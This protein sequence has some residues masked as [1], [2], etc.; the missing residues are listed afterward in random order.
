VNI[1][2]ATEG[3]REAT[4]AIHTAIRVT[5]ADHRGITL[6]CVAP[7]YPRPRRGGR[8]RE[9]YERRVLGEI[10]QILANAEMDLRD[11]SKSRDW[12]RT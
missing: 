7:R 10:A 8:L 11:C 3:S 4:T 1:R 9:D 12:R 2:I 5:S 6:L